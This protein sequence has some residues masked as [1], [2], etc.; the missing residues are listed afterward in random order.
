MGRIN[1]RIYAT[2]RKRS[3]AFKMSATGLQTGIPGSDEGGGR[4]GLFS[5]DFMKRNR[6]G[7]YSQPGSSSVN[8]VFTKLVEEEEVKTEVPRYLDGT[9]GSETSTT[10]TTGSSTSFVPIRYK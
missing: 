6:M 2:R 5:E 1:R 3:S 8:P 10:T 7:E 9:E 4:G